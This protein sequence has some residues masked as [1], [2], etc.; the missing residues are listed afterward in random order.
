LCCPREY[1]AQVFEELYSSA[2]AADIKHLS[3]PAKIIGADPLVPFSFLP[4]VELSDM[5]ALDYDFVPETTH[6]LQLERPQ[7]CVDLM[8]GFLED[9][10]IE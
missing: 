5:V 9:C 7:E 4:S 6:F 2:E 3:C 10:K 8:L 1:E